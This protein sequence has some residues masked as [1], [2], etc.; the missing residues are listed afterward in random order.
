MNNEFL[1]LTA[2]GF[3]VLSAAASIKKKAAHRKTAR[4][5]TVNYDTLME[6]IPV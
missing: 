6:I 1:A 3:V 5:A 4:T 2:A